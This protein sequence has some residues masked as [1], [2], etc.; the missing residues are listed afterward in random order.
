MKVGLGMSVAYST[1]GFSRSWDPAKC[2][3]QSGTLPVFVLCCAGLCP[4]RCARLLLEKSQ[5]TPDW[6][7]N[8]FYRG[9]LSNEA[10]DLYF[11][12]QASGNAVETKKNQGV[13]AQNEAVDEWTEHLTS[14][15]TES[16]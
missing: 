11:E 13:L 3:Y 4:G 14:W 2:W 8:T 16:A 7:K 9:A 10:V 6:T 1:G 5:R 12:V 15:Y